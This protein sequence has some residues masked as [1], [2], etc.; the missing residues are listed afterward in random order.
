[1]EGKKYSIGMDFG[2][3]S[4]RAIL[5]DIEN[6]NEKAISVVGYQDA[7]I[8][9]IL[10]ESGKK[11]PKEYALQNP[12]NYMEA[13]ENLLR[14]IL[15]KGRVAPEQIIGIGV[16]TTASTILPVDRKFVPLC[17]YDQYR[18][19]PHSWIKLWKHHGAQKQAD[20][21]NKIANSMN[22]ECMKYCSGKVSAEWMYPKIMETLEEAPEI[23]DAAYRFMELSDWIVYL[24]TGN[25]TRN[26]IMAFIHAQWDSQKGFPP[27]QFFK[28]LDERMDGLAAKKLG[29]TVRAT[30]EKAGGLTGK[31]AKKTGLPAGTAVAVGNSDGPVA[32]P[33][34]GI[35]NEDTAALILGTSSNLMFLCREKIMIS[36]ATAAAGKGWM[37]GLFGY[38]LGQSAVGDIF[39]WFINN[40]VPY[41]YYK[42][43]EEDGVSI[44]EVLDR[45]VE[46]LK[47]GESGLLALDWFNGNR[48]ILQNADL[49]GVLLGISLTTTPEE[50]YRALIEGTAFGMRKIITTVEES[51]I[52]LNEIYAC[53]G[54]SRKS[55]VI[56]QIFSDVLGLKI[57]VAAS[58]QTVALGSAMTGAVAA[59]SENGGYDNI[60]EAVKHMSKL[61]EKCYETNPENHTR[62]NE[63][64]RQYEELHDYFG[65]TKKDIMSSLRKIR[66]EVM[67]NEY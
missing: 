18:K 20:R 3:L 54:L 39:E 41:R 63:L 66:L 1:M 51:G 16:D 26:S 34:L 13:L 8:D 37:P 56:M 59:G 22:L 28:T 64:Y 14:D 49:T 40:L 6:G 33:G 45:K 32:I 4:A 44:F 15:K 35:V 2:T 42:E 31:M 61:K 36:G 17:F 50:I 5:V 19:N 9:D 53:G 47:P 10:P 38:I 30:F 52:T 25:E 55:P 27:N 24:L 23:F 58:A 65:V 43:A 62:Y 12:H 67:G 48:S 60:T 7:V 57:R 21:F 11:I 46:K 29:E